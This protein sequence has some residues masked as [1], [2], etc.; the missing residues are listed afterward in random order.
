[1]AWKA[2]ATQS[3]A[4]FELVAEGSFSARGW[5]TTA[6]GRRLAWEPTRETGY[7]YVVFEPGGP[8]M[9]TVTAAY[10]L[11]FKG[12]P[13]QMLIAPEA[14]TDPELPALVALGFALACE[15]ALRLHWDAPRTFR[16]T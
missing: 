14:A 9:I 4:G 5:I 13:G 16:G 10:Q 1:M 6:S 3:A 15:Q 7:E 11:T 2:G 8:R 12:N